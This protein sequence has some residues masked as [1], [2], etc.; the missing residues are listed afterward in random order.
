LYL[1]DVKQAQF[2]PEINFGNMKIKYHLVIPG[3]TR[4]I[5]EQFVTSPSSALLQLH[6]NDTNILFYRKVFYNDKPNTQKIRYTAYL[7][8]LHKN[9]NHIIR[10]RRIRWD[11]QGISDKHLPWQQ[12]VL[13]EH[14]HIRFHVK[15]F[16]FRYHIR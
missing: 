5:G 10:I 14:W 12:E 6:P 1:I 9:S 11:T 13:V 4:S 15:Y 8:P 7:Y 2:I 16:W 3:M